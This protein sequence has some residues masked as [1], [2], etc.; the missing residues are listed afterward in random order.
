[1]NSVFVQPNK[2]K[3]TWKEL[4]QAEQF[5]TREKQMNLIHHFK[6]FNFCK[7]LIDGK[8]IFQSGNTLFE[9]EKLKKDFLKT[10]KSS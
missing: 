9:R 4:L 5:K 6:K 3:E 10:K 7:E 2:G 1:M 8:S